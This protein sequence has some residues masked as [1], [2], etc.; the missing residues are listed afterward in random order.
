MTTVPQILCLDGGG[1]RGLVSVLILRSVE[2]ITGRPIHETFDWIG[3]TSTGGILT[4][5][6]LQRKPLNYLLGAYFKLKD[7]VFKGKRPYSSETLENFIKKE[8]GQFS[9]MGDITEPKIMLMTVLADRMP[10]ELHIF[11][12]YEVP[13]LEHDFC[14][15]PFKQFK[16]LPYPKDQPVWE[17]VRA[18]GAAPT[19]FRAS[20]RFIDGGIVANNPTLDVLTEIHKYNLANRKLGSTKG[21]PQMHV[22]VSV[23]TGSPPVKFIEECDVYRPEGIMEFAKVFYGAKNLG[24]LLINQTTESDGQSVSRAAAWCNMINVPFFRFSPQL[25]D[26]IPLDCSD[27]ITLI[28]MLWETQCYLHSRHEKLVQLGKLLL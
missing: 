14:P 7:E 28:N 15:S 24:E 19:Y 23:G 2:N 18:T 27:N 25:S 5:G 16:P 17:A 10:A 21:L 8:F 4:V 6:I 11:K 13:G 20:G 22:V 3:G 9:K 12:N 1:I 26:L